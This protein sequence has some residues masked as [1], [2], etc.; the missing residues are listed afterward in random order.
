M[1]IANPKANPKR[2][3]HRRTAARD[4]SCLSITSTLP[5]EGNGQIADRKKSREVARGICDAAVALMI[6]T[7]TA[8][9]AWT[10]TC[11]AGMSA[12]LILGHAITTT[13]IAAVG[14]IAVIAVVLCATLLR[15][16]RISHTRSLH[17]PSR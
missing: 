6:V 2:M 10:I 3:R 8:L 16:Q 15:A 5:T 14:L 9:T 13:S 12:G 7:G 17:G 11:S 1:A 4:P